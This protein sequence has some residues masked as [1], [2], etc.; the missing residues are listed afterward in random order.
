M[1]LRSGRRL[2]RSPPPHGAPSR[3]GLGGGIDLISA[4]PDEM[5][6]LVLVRLRCVRAAVQT[7]LLSRRWRDLWTGLTDLTFR[8]L[9]PATIKAVLARFAASSTPVSTLGIHLRTRE[10]AYHANLLLCAAALLSPRELVFTLSSSYMGDLDDRI[11][12]P[13]FNCTTSIKLDTERFGVRV[14]DGEFNSLERLSLSGNNNAFSALLHRCHVLRELSITGF[15]SRQLSLPPT[16]E[17]LSLEKLSLNG[18]IVN[19]GTMLTR[20]PRLRVLSATF[21][22]VEPCSIEAALLALE[23]AVALG[24]VVS[25]LGIHIDRGGY[26][27]DANRFSSLLRAATRLS[28]QEVVVTHEIYGHVTIDLPCFHRATSIMMDLHYNISF[29]VQPTSEFSALEM[30]SLSGKCRVLD[31]GT[32]VTCCPRLRTLKATVVGNIIVHSTLLHELDIDRD[33]DTECRGIDIVTPMLKQLQLKVRAGG[34]IGMS[35][36]APAVE[37]VL[38]ERWYTGWPLVFGCWSLKRMRA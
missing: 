32:L 38:W 16:A 24:L 10:T 35:I 5:L 12:L 26:N 15:D 31:I 11:E 30:L 13:C 2:R 20:C 27:V 14:A 8:Y 6:L 23:G 3:R 21:R 7:G 22:G 37:K 9:D 17:F 1:E 28:P 29:T 18:N 4:L 25:L 36:S 19:I 34:D 33:I